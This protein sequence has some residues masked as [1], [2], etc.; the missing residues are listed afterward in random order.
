M[1]LELTFELDKAELPQDNKSIWISY[2]KNVMTNCADGKFYDEYFSSSIVK[3]YAFSIILP[4][5]KFFNNKVILQSNCVKMIFSADD[6]HKTG[7]IFYSA[8]IENKNKRF[9]LPDK[10]AMI[11]KNIRNLQEKKI[12]SK[13]VIFKTVT[14]GG[15]I[16]R[17]HNREQNKDFYYTYADKEFGVQAERVIKQQ[18]VAAGFP[19]SKAD[20]IRIMPL[21]CKK[22]V[23]KQYGIYIDATIGFFEVEADIDILQYFYQAGMGSKHSMGYGM[24]DVV[25][26]NA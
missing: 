26:Q 1:R 25:E 2:L 18:A 22:I 5:P 17:E 7:F 16:I 14:G 21:K 3:D 6:R 12:T 9:L 19:Q 15:L 20:C 24:M 10:N 13:Q 11:L 4:K 8:F 23:V